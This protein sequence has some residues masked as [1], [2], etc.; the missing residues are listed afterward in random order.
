MRAIL[1]PPC[2]IPQYFCIVAAVVSS[3]IK[4]LL[5][6]LGIRT[7]LPLQYGI[8]IVVVIDHSYIATVY[9]S[10]FRKTLPQHYGRERLRRGILRTFVIVFFL[11]IVA[12]PGIVLESWRLSF[13]VKDFNLLMFHS[14]N[15]IVAT[16][17]M[18]LLGSSTCWW[19]QSR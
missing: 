8:C 18:L 4:L 16:S 19:P 10:L 5:C 9:F 17:N 2:T 1:K 11:T 3:S 12:V 13:E 15:S 14:T 7:G 6:L